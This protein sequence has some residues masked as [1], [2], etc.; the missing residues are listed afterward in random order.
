[1]SSKIK[2]ATITDSPKVHSGFG[3]VARM[4]L[5]GF[6]KH[7]FDLYSFGTMDTEY[8]FK[9]ELPYP[10]Q[11]TSGFDPLGYREA[12]LFLTNVQP[13]V[14]FVLYDPGSAMQFLNMVIALQDNG[15]IRQ[16]PIVLY[17]PIEGEP[18]P[19]ST[20][21]L[22]SVLLERNGKVVLYSPK[23]VE[24]VEKQY[25]DFKD[26]LDF[27]YHGL[28]HA[29]FSPLPKQ[30]RDDYRKNVGWSDYFVVG[31]VGVNKRTKGHD[32]LIYTARTLRD[33]KK[34]DG[35][36]FYLHTNPTDGTL[37]GYNLKDMAMNYGVD[38]M[39]IWK[40]GTDEPGGNIRGLSVLSDHK[41]YAKAE[42][43]E[44]RLKAIG[45]KDRLGM[46]DCYVDLSQ[47]EGWGL[48]THEAM[49]CGVPTISIK[50]KSIREEI[51]DGGV[52]W[53]DTLPFRI[54]STLHTGVKLALVDPFDVAEAILELKDSDDVI[55]KF[56]SDCA[57]RNASQYVWKPTQ[58]K[59]I[60]IIEEVYSNY[61]YNDEVSSL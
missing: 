34:D 4:L 40:P 43:D 54:W 22:F 53:V 41:L 7:G 45:Y 5:D 20:A 57:I 44:E 48:P 60:K 50:D 37:N 42:T 36:K 30:I 3:N 61:E 29:A 19:A 2:V 21:K 10:F 26:L 13:D 18:I 11:P 55:K 9:R 39:F 33:M 1:M 14:I 35:I 58:E 16:A 28:D 24:K 23:M 32:Y 47:L 59:F 56:W 27:A 8:D 51:Y 52:L 17:T 49:K 25:P 38:D 31:S 6:Y 12:A 15:T 46:L